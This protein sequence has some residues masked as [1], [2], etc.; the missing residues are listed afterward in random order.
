MTIRNRVSHSG[1]LN[2]L[3]AIAM[4]ICI[5][6]CGSTPKNTIEPAVDAE[7]EGT[8]RMAQFAFDNGHY[9]QAASLYRKA[10]AQAYIRND[11]I[12]ILDGRYNLALC[13]MELKQ[14]PQ[15]LQLVEQAKADLI[16]SGDRP[17]SDLLLLEATILFR[18]DQ[19]TNSWNVTE[20]ILSTHN[21]QNPIIHAKTHFLRGL[22]ADRRNDVVALRETISVMGQPENDLLKS[23]LSELNGRLAMAEKDWSRASWFLDESSRLRKK[24]RDYRRMAI[25]LSLA[26]EAAENMEETSVAATRY[27]QAGRSAA[28]NDDPANARKW[29]SQAAVL[30][31]E[32]D[33]EALAAEARSLLDEMN[34]VE[35][36]KDESY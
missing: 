23:D 33:N 25:T 3:L 9:G 26:A 8:Q 5:N 24:N 2:A 19:I 14:Y 31:D 10:L 22:I 18:K 6:G 7:A 4:V 11:S 17:P 30:F 15:A 32:I 20:T 12:A 16:T 36:T 29:L 28:L 27:L 1:A 21:E 34:D 35:K 13:L